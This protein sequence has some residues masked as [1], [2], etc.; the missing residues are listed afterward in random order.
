MCAGDGSAC[1]IAFG[2]KF[3][4]E[5]IQNGK[6]LAD[7]QK[8]VSSDI[9]EVLLLGFNGRFDSGIPR[10]TGHAA[11][12]F[13]GLS[14]ADIDVG[15]AS[16]I[17][18]NLAWGFHAGWVSITS[19]VRDTS[20][21]CSKTDISAVQVE[22]D[23][24]SADVICSGSDNFVLNGYSAILGG[25]DNVVVGNHSVVHGGAGNRVT[26]AGS[27]V[28]GG[29]ANRVTGD[30]STV[31]GGAKNAVIAQYSAIL[32]GSSNYAISNYASVAGGFRNFVRSRHG[33]VVGGSFNTVGGLRSV[34][35]GQYALAVHDQSLVLSFGGKSYGQ[36]ASNADNSINVCADSLW[37][38]DYDVG[39]CYDFLLSR[40]LSDEPSRVE[41]YVLPPLYCAN[42]DVW[43]VLV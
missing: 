24:L 15:L 21:A 20:G 16:S 37:V 39:E 8:R 11:M 23:L 22:F 29:S 25:T 2:A 6:E 17:E 35:M 4:L 33:V 18:T 28:A 1:Y 12:V 41:E 38:N 5:N 3:M 30:Y 43:V 26:G 27:L 32:G 42:A 14:N 31:G 19:R 40:R 7:L 34:A 13:C 10:T 9:S 36:C